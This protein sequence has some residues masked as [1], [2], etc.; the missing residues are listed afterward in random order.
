MKRM[1]ITGLEYCD[2]LVYLKLYLLQRRCE[3]Y[4]II[5][6]WKIIEGL[7]PNFSK[8]I[9]CS[10]SARRGWSCIVSHVH[11]DRLGSFAY[12][13]FR[14]RAICLFNVMP[15][16]VRC[17]SSCS[18]RFKKELDCYLRNIVDLPSMSGFNNSWTTTNKVL[19]KSPVN[20]NQLNKNLHVVISE[21]FVF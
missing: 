19:K 15:K 1:I 9:I 20:I 18:V 13:S 11:L 12:N 14:W 17:I 6:V 3:L 8:P 2:W 10:F 7:V 21:G 5:Y 16:Y 4:C